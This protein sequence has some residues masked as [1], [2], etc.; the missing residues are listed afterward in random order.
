MAFG[1]LAALALLLGTL[2]PAATGRASAATPQSRVTILEKVRFAADLGTG[3]FAFHHFVYARYQN[4]GFS[5]GASERVRNIAKAAVALLFSYHQLR[6]AQ[7]VANNSKSPTL[8]ALAT[9]L[10][11]LDNRV[12]QVYSDLH[13]GQ[14]HPG[15]ITSLNNSYNSYNTR[16]TAAGYAVKDVPAAL[17]GAA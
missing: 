17:P 9:P 5:S 10:N 7:K 15:E 3:F 11:A 14:Y 12:N 16:S 8:H 2:A 1:T 6:A 4:G 13:N